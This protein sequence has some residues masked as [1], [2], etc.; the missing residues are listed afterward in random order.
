MAESPVD[1]VLFIMSFIIIFAAMA[2]P[3]LI[4][5]S[6]KVRTSIRLG[7]F[8]DLYHAFLFGM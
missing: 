1:E 7:S 3:F 8:L 5:D 6:R 2:F 4:A